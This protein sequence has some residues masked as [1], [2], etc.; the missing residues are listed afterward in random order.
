MATIYSAIAMPDEQKISICTG[1]PGARRW[2]S[3]APGQ[4]GC[5]FNLTLCEGPDRMVFDMKKDASAEMWKTVRVMGDDTPER[6]LDLW[7]AAMESYW[8]GVWWMDRAILE[9]KD[10]DK[11]SSWGRSA[12]SFA[13]AILQSETV[14]EICATDELSGK[15]IGDAA[16]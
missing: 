15:L 9:K 1:N 3:L 16:V 13:E 10:T 12:T 11:A 7:D 4:M 2:G 8:Q 14:R 6:A 5:Y